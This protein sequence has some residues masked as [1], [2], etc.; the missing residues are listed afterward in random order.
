MKIVDVYLVFDGMKSQIVGCTND[1]PTTDATTGQPGRK[2][3]RMVVTTANALLDRRTTELS[4]P[5]N[6]RAVKKPSLFQVG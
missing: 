6:E 2:T 5:N 1:F 4:R 3:V